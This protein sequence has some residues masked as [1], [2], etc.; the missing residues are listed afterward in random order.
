[1]DKVNQEQEGYTMLY[2]GIVML[3]LLALV[4]IA[5]ASGG[6]MSVIQRIQAGTPDGDPATDVRA[7]S[8]AETSVFFAPVTGWIFSIVLS[9]VFVSQAI[10]GTLFPNITSP[11]WY[12]TLWNAPE[13]AKWM[14][15]AFVAGFSERL[16]PDM[17]D[18][19]TEQREA[20]G[21]TPASAGGHAFNADASNGQRRSSTHIR[22][23]FL[24]TRPN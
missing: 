8:L 1:L 19:L 3:A 16:V 21:T 15:W 5:G 10:K 7:L 6:L 23:R 18:T 12:Y 11:D 24:S 2:R 14:F 20:S 22:R 17:L 13:M 9:L 4:G